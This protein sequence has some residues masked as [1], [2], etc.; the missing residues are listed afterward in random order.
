MLR[1]IKHNYRLSYGRLSLAHPKDSLKF[2]LKRI[3]YWMWILEIHLGKKLNSKYDENATMIL[4]SYKRI[5]NIEPIVKSALKCSF[6]SK[7]IV[8][9]NNPAEYD[10]ND[11]MSFND[12][13][14]VLINQKKQEG[15]GIRWDLALNE[16]CKNFIVIDDDVFIKPHQLLK[17]FESLIADKNVPH[18]LAGSINF[19]VFVDRKEIEVEMLHQI[20]AVTDLHIAKYFEYKNLL[21]QIPSLKNINIVNSADD[22]LISNTGTRN[23]RIHETGFIL[24]C[25]SSHDSDIACYL[26]EGFYERRR[27]ILDELNEMKAVERKI[28]EL[29]TVDL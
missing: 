13:R 15:F 24:R 8:S 6:I 23:S 18:G 22:I 7:I 25:P 9:N 19:K 2:L 3:L 21:E 12:P 5:K 10:L 29:Q 16:N 1:I 17:L 26:Q 4:L 28:N 27:K 11:W 20:Y 14:V